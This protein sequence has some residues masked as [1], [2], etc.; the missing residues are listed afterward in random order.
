MLWHFAVDLRAILYTTY[1]YRIRELNVV[2]WTQGL[3]L[4]SLLLALALAWNLPRP[5]ETGRPG[6]KGARSKT[7][8]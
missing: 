8:L 3:I 1:L 6:H 2:W 7:R 5:R 4:L